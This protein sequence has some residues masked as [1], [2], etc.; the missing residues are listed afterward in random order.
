MTINCVLT[1]FSLGPLLQ[2][3]REL[4]A[5][6]GLTLDWDMVAARV[7]GQA[8]SGSVILGAIGWYISLRKRTK[9]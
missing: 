1:G 4:E 9:P 3:P 5:W 8:I 6:S 7:L 2:L